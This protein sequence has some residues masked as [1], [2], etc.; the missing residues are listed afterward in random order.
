M[1]TSCRWR[2]LLTTGLGLGLFAGAGCQTWTYQ[3]GM[4]LP[5]PHYLEHPPQ[6]FPPDPEFPLEREQ[7]AQEEAALAE[8]PPGGGAIP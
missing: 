4:T 3:S 6:Y 7:A 2:W 1:R 8:P 5:S